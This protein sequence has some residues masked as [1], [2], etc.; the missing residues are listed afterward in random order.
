VTQKQY[1]VTV[2][3]LAYDFFRIP[4]LPPNAVLTNGLGLQSARLLG[5]IHPGCSVVRTA[6]N[7]PRYPLLPVVLFPGNVGDEFGLKTVYQ[8]LAVQ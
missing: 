1:R 4:R 6:D 3:G 5:Q 7:H 2:S 8:R